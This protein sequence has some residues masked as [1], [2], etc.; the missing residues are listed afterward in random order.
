[1]YLILGNITQ[2]TSVE[3]VAVVIVF[4]AMATLNRKYNI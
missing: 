4:I 2:M 1:M 3:V